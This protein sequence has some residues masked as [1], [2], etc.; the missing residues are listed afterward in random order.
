MHRI[1]VGLSVFLVPLILFACVQLGQETEETP[2]VIEEQQEE[3]VEP[4]PPPLEEEDL[5]TRNVTY[6]G[7]LEEGGVT[8][9]QEG[10]HRLMLSDGKMVLLEPAEGEVIPLSLYVSK[11]VRVQGDVSPTVEAGGTIMEVKEIHWIRREV[12]EEGDEEEVLRVLC[13]GDEG[14]VCPEGFV[15]ELGEEEG[16]CVRSADASTGSA[17]SVSDFEDE[18]TDESEEEEVV[19]D[20]GSSAEEEEQTSEASS[21]T[22]EAADGTDQESE[23]EE[24][25]KE[26][27]APTNGRHAKSLELMMDEDYAAERWT[28]EY[29]SEHV[30]FCIPVHKNWYYK[31]FGAMTSILWH[32]EMGAQP[33]EV[34]GDG[35]LL[36]ELKSGDLASIGVTDGEVKTVGSKVIGYRAWSEGRHFEVTAPSGVEEAV[37][38]VTSGLRSSEE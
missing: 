27:L 36:V 8:I 23:D 4:P 14:A 18:V 11:L 2:A 9:Y 30:G 22:D 16:V 31:S 17:E 20:E 35:P 3:A 37:R 24:E 29:C 28:Q 21:E 19:E 10:S 12:D 15:C 25:Q 38:F 13:G 32:V 5:V 6:T 7:I 33:V 34:M 1:L 26:E